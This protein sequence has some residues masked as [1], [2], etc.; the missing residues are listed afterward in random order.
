[1]LTA[2][3]A[4]MTNL[5]VA[6]P[7]FANISVIQFQPGELDF[8]IDEALG[9]VDTVV[10]VG[11]TDCEV[12]PIFQNLKSQTA[13]HMVFSRI[14]L[15]ARIWRRPITDDTNPDSMETAAAIGA[16]WHQYVP[17][18]ASSPVV[19]E[20]IVMGA[21]QTDTQRKGWLTWDVIASTID[22][23]NYAVPTIETPVIVDSTGTVT[24]TC[25]TI[26]AAIFYST[27]GTQPAPRKAD[28]DHPGESIAGNLYTTPFS[29]TGGTTVRAK[30]WL[31]GYLASAETTYNG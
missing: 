20:K 25:G 14:K 17:V 13:Y 12:K 10:V 22:G 26:G 8:I 15:F 4:E 28:P 16:I 30:A 5:L 27:D 18:G 7:W 24:I 2:L 23:V 21:D 11:I 1:M 19:T 6:D 29:I 9:K 31:A 3:R